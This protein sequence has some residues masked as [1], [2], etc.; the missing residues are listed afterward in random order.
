MKKQSNTNA[1]K[2]ILQVNE[3][4]SLEEQISQRAYDLWLQRGGEHGW[5]LTDLFQAEKEIR[6]WHQARL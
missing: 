4:L 2:L 1:A 6:E 3:V 5:D